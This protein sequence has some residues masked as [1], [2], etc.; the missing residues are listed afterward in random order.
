MPDVKLLAFKF[1]KSTVSK[2]GA[3]PLLARKNLPSLLDVPFG[4]FANVTAWSAIEVVITL[5]GMISCEPTE[6]VASLACVT[7]SSCILVV[8]TA[9]CCKLPAP[10]ALVASL[11][12]VTALAAILLYVT[13]LLPS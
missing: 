10:T 12:F 9:F 1:A 4:S 7:A 13:T 3:A 6:L 2:V 11:A 5:L 8:S